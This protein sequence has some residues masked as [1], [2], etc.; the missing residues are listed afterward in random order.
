MENSWQNL[1]DII[2]K[3]AVD[4]ASNGVLVANN[5]FHIFQKMN[6]NV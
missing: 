1:E 3:I 4:K 6:L 2:S 5:I